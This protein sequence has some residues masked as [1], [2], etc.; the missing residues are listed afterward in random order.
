MIKLVSVLFQQE[1]NEVLKNLENHHTHL[2]LPTSIV[3]K[4]GISE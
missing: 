1:K 2:K 4:E 3:S